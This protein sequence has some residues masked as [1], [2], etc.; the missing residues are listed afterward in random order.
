L[1]T[2]LSILQRNSTITSK[3]SL[4]IFFQNVGSQNFAVLGILDKILVF[5]KTHKFKASPPQMEQTK[6]QGNFQQNGY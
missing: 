1:G 3:Q 2:K 4:E 6:Y 5:S